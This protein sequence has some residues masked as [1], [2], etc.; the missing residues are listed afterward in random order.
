MELVPFNPSWADSGSKL[1]LRGIYQRGDVLAPLPIRRHNDHSRK[2]WAYVTLASVA[3]VN[4]VVGYVKSLGIDIG[5]LQASYERNSA[6]MF[7]M[8]DYAAEQPKRDSAEADQIK[9]RL[10]QL[11]SKG[12]KG[13]A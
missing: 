13:A 5:R 2:G 6:G 10:A 1:D 11:E 9:T 8:Q 12:K 7:K 4:E 3:D